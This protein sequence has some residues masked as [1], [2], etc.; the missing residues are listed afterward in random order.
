VSEFEVPWGH[1]TQSVKTAEPDFGLKE[2][3][4]QGTHAVEP[5]PSAYVPAAQG[6]HLPLPED[7]VRVPGGHSWQGTVEPVNG[8]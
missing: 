4:A 5:V 8:P 2:P 1:K 6:W 7:V 3:A